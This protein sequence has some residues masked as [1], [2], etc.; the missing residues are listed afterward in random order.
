MYS[1]HSTDENADEDSV[2]AHHTT[3]TPQITYNDAEQTQ[4]YNT[5]NNTETHEQQE[6]VY[7]TECEQRNIKQEKTDE[8]IPDVPTEPTLLSYENCYLIS[9]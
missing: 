5:L 8:H 3:D 4:K 7:E 9:H 1:A 2:D 6:D